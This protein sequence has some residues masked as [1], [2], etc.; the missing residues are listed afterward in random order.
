MTGLIYAANFWDTTI[1]GC[2]KTRQGREKL[3]AGAKA[4]RIFNDF[5]T[6]EVVPFPKTCVNQSFS[7]A[8]K[9]VPFPKPA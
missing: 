1:G 2:G 6:T 7:A 3:T 5:G 9:L 8:C 4:Q